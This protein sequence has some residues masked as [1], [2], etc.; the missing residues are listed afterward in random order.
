MSGRVL[1]GGRDCGPPFTRAI[2]FLSGTKKRKEKRAG[3]C[4]CA[5]RASKSHRARCVV[6]ARGDYSKEGEKKKRK[7][8]G[9]PE[10]LD[11]NLRMLRHGPSARIAGKKRGG[12]KTWGQLTFPV[13]VIEALGTL[14]LG[15]FCSHCWRKKERRKRKKVQPV[16]RV[17]ADH[18]T[19]V[20]CGQRAFALDPPCSR[21]HP[22]QGKRGGREKREEKGEGRGGV[23]PGPPI[24]V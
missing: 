8:G 2:T 3:A 19:A 13:L 5:K 4:I 11:I 1:R 24:I 16:R 10:A 22:Q 12:R 18:L 17:D 9:T 21:S 23:L 7:G 20:L 6:G 15:L 14:L